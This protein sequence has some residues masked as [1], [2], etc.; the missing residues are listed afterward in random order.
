LRWVA[1]KSCLFIAALP[2]GI[3]PFRKEILIMNTTR[4]LFAA[5]FA[6]GIGVQMSSAYAATV[7]TYSSKPTYAVTTVR[8]TSPYWGVYPAPC[9]YGRVVV[10]GTVPAATV[11]VVPPPKPPVRVVVAPPPVTVYPAPRVVYTPAPYYRAP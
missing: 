7:V 2:R 11:A 5:A 6:V 1:R 4:Y 10:T 3:S 8:T 9:C